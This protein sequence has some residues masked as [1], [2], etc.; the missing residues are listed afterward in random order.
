[1]SQYL[2]IR[3]ATE[4]QFTVSPGRNYDTAQFSFSLSPPSGP[5]SATLASFFS[6]ETSANATRS[7]PTVM[8]PNFFLERKIAVRCVAVRAGRVRVVGRA[9]GDP[10]RARRRGK[11]PKKDAH[12]SR[13]RPP[14]SVH[15]YDPSFASKG[16]PEGWN[17]RKDACRSGGTNV[18]NCPPLELVVEERENWR[19]EL[20]YVPVRTFSGPS[21]TT[22]AIYG[23]IC[24][25]VGF[26]VSF[27]YFINWGFNY[28]VRFL[29]KKFRI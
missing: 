26:F 1:M 23:E 7:H 12:V 16:S 9:R 6:T 24:V 14:R 3:P 20:M 8:R 15:A 18:S 17:S 25:N 27:R 11:G 13:T 28:I 22:T 19:R 5:V 21:C 4:R 10:R 29:F 2:F